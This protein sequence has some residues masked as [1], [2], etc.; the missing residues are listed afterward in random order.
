MRV[1][2]P[3][4]AALMLAGP[5]CS[6][7]GGQGPSTGPTLRVSVVTTGL[8]FDNDGYRVVV[9]GT[10]VRFQPQ[11]VASAGFSLP[12]GAYPLVVSLSDIPPNCSV[13]GQHPR[14][15][16]VALGAAT[17]AAFEIVCS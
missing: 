3:A 5:A 11:S 10:S 13:S 4:L 12:P 14:T 2:T 8:D 7:D 1:R 17:D 6:G 15:I 16:S 9:G